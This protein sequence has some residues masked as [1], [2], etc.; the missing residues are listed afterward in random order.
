MT[1]PCDALKQFIYLHDGAPFSED[2]PQINEM[3]EEYNWYY[4][5]PF[6]PLEEDP[7]PAYYGLYLLA[8]RK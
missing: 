1:E 8:K 5:W 3:I 4:E 6:L 7:F 2:L